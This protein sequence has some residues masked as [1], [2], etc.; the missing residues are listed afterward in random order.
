MRA[1]EWDK[2]KTKMYFYHKLSNMLFIIVLSTDQCRSWVVCCLFMLLCL[3]NMR[4]CMNN[5][6]PV[7]L[8]WPSTVHMCEFRWYLLKEKQT[9]ILVFARSNSQLREYLLMSKYLYC[10]VSKSF[11][12]LHFHGYSNTKSE[13]TWPKP[14]HTPNRRTRNMLQHLTCAW[15]VCLSGTHKCIQYI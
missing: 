9:L 15:K 14:P 6:T 7:C 11:M 12:D 8:L 4:L 13:Q 2:D 1:D 5:L 3:K 10:R